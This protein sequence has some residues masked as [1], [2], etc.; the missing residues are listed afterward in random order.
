[1][2]E[3]ISVGCF[4]RGGHLSG[5]VVE[6]VLRGMCAFFGG[7]R[8]RMLFRKHANGDLGR[9]SRGSCSTAPDRKEYSMDFGS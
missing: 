1:M 3:Y 9:R 2:V 5:L 4:D 6:E 7:L 8:T